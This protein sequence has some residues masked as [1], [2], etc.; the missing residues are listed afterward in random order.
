MDD[1]IH[2]LDSAHER[3]Y[4]RMSAE[5]MRRSGRLE[6]NCIIDGPGYAS[7]RAAVSTQA[8]PGLIR[9]GNASNAS[10]AS[11]PTRCSMPVVTRTRNG[12]SGRSLRSQQGTQQHLLGSQ[13]PPGRRRCRDR[14]ATRKQRNYSSRSIHVG[15]N[16]HSRP[17]TNCKGRELALLGRIEEAKR[18]AAVPLRDIASG[19]YLL[20]A[21]ASAA[22][23]AAGAKRTTG[24]WIKRCVAS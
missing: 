16:R 10:R 4:P 3:A 17:T 19:D 6:P 12:T 24:D 11:M 5:R 15:E 18:S 2:L 20:W 1:L 23:C 9:H 7:E 21:R 13:I 8:S 14:G 22:F